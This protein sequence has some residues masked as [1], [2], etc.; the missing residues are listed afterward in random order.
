M[1]IGKS[2][3]FFDEVNFAFITNRDEGNIVHFW[4]LF[5]LVFTFQ[6]ILSYKR[7]QGT[8]SLGLPFMLSWYCLKILIFGKYY[9]IWYICPNRCK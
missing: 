7:L 4:Q 5:A 8:C 9:Q 1:E 6:Q 2:L 3:G